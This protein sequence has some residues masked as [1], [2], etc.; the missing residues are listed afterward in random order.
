M[1]VG[2]ISKGKVY[3]FEKEISEGERLADLLLFGFNGLGEVCYEKELKG[4]SGYFE[5]VATLSKTC[6]N[7]VVCGCI[8]DTRGLKRKSVVVAE[9]GKIL[10]ISDMLHAV[11]GEVNSGGAVKL[12]DTEIGKIGV[13][14]AEDLLFPDVVRS[15]SLCGAECIL[16]PFGRVYDS[17][18]SVLLRAYAYCY[19]VP[20]LFC[21]QGYS[22]AAEIDGSLLFASPQSPIYLDVEWKKEYHLVEIRRR[23]CY[24]P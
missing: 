3:D 19:G 15:L 2:F 1:R 9:K 6:K 11:D 7:L 20:I 22:L 13:A 17:V 23:G 12:Y 21:A 14:V 4:E 8:T 18:Q 16:C 24:R 10:G 5:R